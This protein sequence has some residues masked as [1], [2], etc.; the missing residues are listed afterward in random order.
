MPQKSVEAVSTQRIVRP[1]NV[2]L[3]L[4][5]VILPQS[6]SFTAP[7]A[8]PAVGVKNPVALIVPVMAAELSRSGE[9]RR[10]R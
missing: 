2:M 9:R 6:G 5:V 3:A 8:P 1:E 7:A 10:V 4:I